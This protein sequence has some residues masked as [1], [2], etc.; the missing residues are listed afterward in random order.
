L[1][2]NGAFGDGFI[3]GELVTAGSTDFELVTAQER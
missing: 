2:N 1:V 3:T